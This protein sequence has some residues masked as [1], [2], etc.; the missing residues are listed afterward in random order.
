MFSP[1]RSLLACLLAGLLISTSA[2]ATVIRVL[3]LDAPGEGFLDL[4]PAEP[5]GGNPGTTR[6]AQ[7]LAVF[8]HAA[9]IWAARVKSSVE[10]AVGASFDPLECDDS[11]AL[12]GFAGPETVHRDF[13]GAPR[14]RT[15]YTQAE[16]NS[17]AGVDLDPGSNDIFMAFNSDVG[18]SCPFPDGWYY[19]LDGAPPPGRTDL[20][21][22]VLHEMGH[23]LGFLTLVDAAL[24]TKFRR[25]DDV[26]MFGLEEH[27]GGAIFPAM[28]NAERVAASV[29]TGSLHWV[30]SEVVAAGSALLA[31][32]EP[33]S[34]HVEMYAPKPVEDGSSVSH[35]SDSLAP[36]QL[37]EPFYTGPIHDPGLAGSLL[38]DLGW[39]SAG[40]G[41]G[42][43]GAG[44]ECDDGNELAADGCT[45]C[46]IDACYRCA[47]YP[48]RCVP[49]DG[50]AC[51]DGEPCTAADVCVAGVCVGSTADGLPCDDG[52]PCSREDQCRAGACRGDSTPRSDCKRS[53]QAGKSFLSLKDGASEAQDKLIWKW[54]AGEQTGLAEFGDPTRATDYLLCMYD[55]SGLHGGAVLTQGVPGGS[56]WNAAGGGFKYVG[57]DG[58]IT[59]VRLKEGKRG[60]ARIIVKG[61]GAALGVTGLD[62]LASPITVQLG[63]ANAC[64][65]ATYGSRVL[66]AEPQEFKA[67]SD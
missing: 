54:L 52:D 66:K 14:S 42:A 61:K 37:M 29:D 33:L 53:V 40:C 10:I 46:R 25:L 34:G 45:Q 44:E 13:V 12:L 39:V 28:T 8:E 60:S 23:G 21:T 58:G 9:S 17:L 35:F 11:S 5:V 49:N 26:F 55:E 56:G 6:G 48:S 16:A 57:R 2:G 18:V 7:R 47:G 51:D 30:G 19:G 64:W 1:A 4:T 67:K 3:S 38:L 31:G 65:E 43:A 62:Q 59:L 15:W 41:D 27:G 24:G 50:A 32:R 20:V 63:N 36:N 22:V